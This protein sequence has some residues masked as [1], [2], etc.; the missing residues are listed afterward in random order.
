[1]IDITEVEK[2]HA[3]LIE[4]FGGANAVRDR[5]LLESAI[6]RPFAT[7][8]DTELYPDPIDKA[9]AILES[10]LINHPF[11]DGN[12][13]TGYVLARLLL[14]ENGCDISASQ[15]DKYDFVIAVSKGEMRFDGIRNWLSLHVL[16]TGL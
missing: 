4:K 1:M 15:A 10:I 16:K 14:M 3:I 11:T 8:G 6:H 12:K 7:F 9:A 2:I 13:R 5:G